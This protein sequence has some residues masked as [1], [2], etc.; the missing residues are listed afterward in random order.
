MV[1]GVE[2]KI[3]ALIN[4]VYLYEFVFVFVSFFSGGNMLSKLG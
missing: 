4:S 1:V 2:W 3:Y